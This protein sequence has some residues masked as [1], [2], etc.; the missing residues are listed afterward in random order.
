MSAR[1]L[2]FAFAA[3]A[4]LA[5]CGVTVEVQTDPV[6]QE[7]PV[8]SLGV[9]AYAEIAV[10]IPPE[11]RGDITIREISG[12]V[13]IVN[14]APGTDMNLSL[15]L[16]TQGTATPDTP[17]LFTAANKPAYYDTAIALL[18]PKVYTRNSR[19][20]ETIPART[21]DITAFASAV[22][23][24]RIWLIVG[25]TITSAGLGDVLPLKIRLEGLVVRVVVDKSLQ[26]LSNGM[27]VAGL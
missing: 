10:D 11:A 12:T 27:D 19:T 6:S 17:Y 3:G 14:P 4:L 2:V 8:T 7:I 18:G 25:N 13:T 9:P 21:E 23:N 20:L 24:E 26:G 15:R 16:S 1:S 22:R 5:G